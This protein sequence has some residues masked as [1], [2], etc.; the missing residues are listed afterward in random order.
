MRYYADAE[1]GAH[2]P[3]PTWDDVVV[4]IR[5]LNRSDNTFF[6]IM[7][8]RDDLPWGASVA[9]GT[10]P[11]GGYDVGRHDTRTGEDREHVAADP[12]AIA[13]DLMDWVTLR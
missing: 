1:G 11:L 9:I 13:T 2:I 3:E 4:L 6:V 10:G 5:G 7:P 8:D 12:M